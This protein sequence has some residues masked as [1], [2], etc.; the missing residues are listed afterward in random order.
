MGTS[1]EKKKKILG[2]GT[3]AGKSVTCQRLLARGVQCQQRVTESQSTNHRP[4]K[5]L[6][7]PRPVWLRACGLRPL[8][9]VVTVCGI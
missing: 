9:V 8:R 1:Q 7:K 2:V 3:V 4:R 6:G 5:A